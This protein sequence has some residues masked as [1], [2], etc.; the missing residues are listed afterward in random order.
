MLWITER[1][2][3]CAWRKNSEVQPNEGQPNEKETG[4]KTVTQ[5]CMQQNLAKLYTEVDGTEC[6]DYAQNNIRTEEVYTVYSVFSQLYDRC[7]LIQ[8]IID[9]MKFLHLCLSPSTITSF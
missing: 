8:R 5:T 2:K 9:F 4:F 6:T 7:Q 1:R 3:T